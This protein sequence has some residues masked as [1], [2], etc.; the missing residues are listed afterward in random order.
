M[1]SDHMPEEGEWRQRHGEMKRQWKG[2]QIQGKELS[3]QGG[4]DCGEEKQQAL[5]AHLWKSAAP[6][7]LR[8]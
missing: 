3:W 2:E 8:S 7:R 5:G 6:E 4:G 1:E